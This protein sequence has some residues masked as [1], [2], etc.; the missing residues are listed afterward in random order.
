MLVDHDSMNLPPAIAGI[1][2]RALTWDDFKGTPPEDSPYVAHI[3]WSINYQFTT[4]KEGKKPRLKVQVGV[5]PKSW[6]VKEE[7][8]LLRHEY[9]HYLIGCLCALAFLKRTSHDF[10]DP[11][12]SYPDWY[13]QVL[14]AC[15]KEYCAM[16]R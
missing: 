12:I 16:E 5:R 11:K 8:K 13:K 9:G 7:L 2:I 15:L 10:K 6:R 3:Y 14:A 4:C 1:P